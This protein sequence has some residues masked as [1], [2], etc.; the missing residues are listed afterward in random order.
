MIE[1][2]GIGKP[3]LVQER[4]GDDCKNAFKVNLRYK[5]GVN[6]EGIWA[7]GCTDAD[8]AK[9][10]DDASKGESFFVYLLNDP[11]HPGLKW[12]SKIECVTNGDSRPYSRGIADEAAASYETQ[13]EK[14]RKHVPR[15]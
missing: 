15:N 8:N 4:A 6:G 1:D 9:Q 13:V 3:E 2:H 10:Q 7:V 5:E 14:L 11:V 12:G